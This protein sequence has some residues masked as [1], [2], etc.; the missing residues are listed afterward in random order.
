MC[1]IIKTIRKI[2]K[3]IEGMNSKNNTNNILSY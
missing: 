3:N 1:I 2:F